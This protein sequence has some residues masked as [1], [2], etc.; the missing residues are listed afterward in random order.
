MPK[1]GGSDVEQSGDQPVE[2]TRRE[3]ARLYA[4]GVLG[5]IIV[6]FAFF[7]LRSVK[8]D[9]VAGSGHSPLIL[10]IVIAFLVGAVVGRPLLSRLQESARRK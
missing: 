8:V 9:W 7:N 3:Q 1:A 5:A 4:A 6:L 2:R 10:V